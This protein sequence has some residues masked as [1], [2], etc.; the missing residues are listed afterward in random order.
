MPRPTGRHDEDDP[1][2]IALEMRWTAGWKL[3]QTL[4]AAGIAW[5]FFDGA[6]GRFADGRDPDGVAFAMFGLFLV[7]AAVNTLYTAVRAWRARHGGKPIALSDGED[8][9]IAGL[10]R[11]DP[12]SIAL[13]TSIGVVLAAGCIGWFVAGARIAWDTVLFGLLVLGFA[14]GLV[15]Y[16][17]SGAR[18]PEEP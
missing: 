16:A 1:A 17:L 5:M 15:W 8:A 4:I 9:L 12:K 7:L 18:E 3:V 10:E 13:L 6:A 14:A 11:G 2:E